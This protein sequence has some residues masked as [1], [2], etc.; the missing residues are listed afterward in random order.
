[1]TQTRQVVT[2]RMYQKATMSIT[3]TA[4]RVEKPLILDA[5]EPAPEPKPKTVEGK[6]GGKRRT[7]RRQAKAV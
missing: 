1:M 7:S 2:K 4:G 6:N 5:P 3:G